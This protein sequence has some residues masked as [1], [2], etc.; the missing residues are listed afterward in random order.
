MSLHDELKNDLEML[1]ILFETAFNEIKDTKREILK[2][3]TK[4]VFERFLD[5]ADK[6]NCLNPIKTAEECA[7]IELEIISKKPL[8]EIYEDL[9]LYQKL[10]NK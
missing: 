1:N 3:L 8:I 4:L 5:I 7:K 2:D 10:L 6:E 9:R